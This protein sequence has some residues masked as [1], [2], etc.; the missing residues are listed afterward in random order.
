[1]ATLAGALATNAGRCPNRTALVFADHSYTYR[2][3]DRAVNRTVHALTAAGLRKGDRM[4]LMTANSDGFYIALYAAWRLGALVVP[5]NPASPAPELQYLLDDSGATLIVFDEGAA[6]AVRKRDELPAPTLVSRPIALGPVEGYPNLFDLAATGPDTAPNI[7][8]VETDDAAILYTSGTTGR[9]KGALFDHHRML[10]VG[11]NAALVLGLRDGD[12]ILHV[13][14][15][16]HSAALTMTVIGGTQI[17]ATHVI[18]PG[19]T[20]DDVLDAFEEHKIT[21]FF[22]VPT[23]YQLLLRHPSLPTRDL[24]AWRVGVFGAAPMPASAVE[25]AI[26]ALPQVE[27]IQACGQTE[28]G[29][30][31]IYSSAEEVRARPDASGRRALFNTEARVVDVDGDDVEPGGTGELILRGETVMKEYWRNPVATAQTIRGGW[32]HTGDIATI[33]AEGYITLVDRMKDMI[34]SGGRNVYSVE[35]EN[36]LAAHPAVSDIAI[37]ARK[38]PDYGETVVAI[39]DPLPGQTVTLDELREFGAE[40]LSAYKLPRELVVRDIPRNP[41][42]KTLKHVLRADLEKAGA[43]ASWVGPPQ[44][45]LRE[46]QLN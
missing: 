34:I 35:V 11:I 16:Y 39:V 38:H 36:A 10:W 31:G 17:G 18:L 45:P 21:M 40:R 46:R 2:E 37:V 42:G 13:A 30:G 15:M 23:M 24:S 33:D 4:L 44:E 12:R 9:P 22:G 27:L 29:P 25:A 41:S 3:L 14:P 8:V 32:L 26:R 28:G 6:V 1:M 5:V 20:P 19:F 7:E 43:Q